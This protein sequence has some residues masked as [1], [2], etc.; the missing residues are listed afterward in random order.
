[1]GCR[2]PSRAR[3]VSRKFTPVSV[4]AL[5]LDAGLCQEACWAEPGVYSLQLLLPPAA[6]LARA[7]ADSDA[8]L[9][10]V[11]DWAAA[12]LPLRHPFLFYAAHN[13]AFAKLKLLPG[14]PPSPFDVTFCRGID[15]DVLDPRQGGVCVGVWGGET[16]PAATVAATSAQQ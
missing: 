12:P 11:A 5:A 15:P 1:M 7:W 10:R 3:Q 13:A 6:A 4:A 9:G 8:L 16:L 14:A 2:P